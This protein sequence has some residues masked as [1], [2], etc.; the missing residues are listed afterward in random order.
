MGL[1]D[2]F[3]VS[4]CAGVRE[5]IFGE[6]YK[7]K[8]CQ[9]HM[10]A[11]VPL[12]GECSVVTHSYVSCAEFN[13]TLAFERGAWYTLCYEWQ[14]GCRYCRLH[15]FCT[16]DYDEEC[17]RIWLAARV[18]EVTNTSLNL[19]V[20]QSQQHGGD[21]LCVQVTLGDDLPLTGT[22]KVTLYENSLNAP[23]RLVE[24][25]SHAAQPGLSVTFSSREPLRPNTYYVYSICL[26]VVPSE[27]FKQR[28]ELTFSPGAQIICRNESSKTIGGE[29][30]DYIDDTGA[31]HR[32]HATLVMYVLCF[33]VYRIVA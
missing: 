15:V 2:K 6:P 32:L 12:I 30:F 27:A 3:P 22:L 4:R 7:E 17:A 13:P 24:R 29:Y 31:S 1:A 26:E 20:C 28:Y 33:I 9:L 8:D 5:L 14:S 25:S 11:T 23:S 19:A 18:L 10:G 16:H 21:S